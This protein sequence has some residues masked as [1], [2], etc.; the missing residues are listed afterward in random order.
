MLLD[1]V[2]KRTQ[3]TYREESSGKIVRVT[4]EPLRL[5]EL[6]A[7]KEDIQKGSLHIDEMASR[8][9]ERLGLLNATT[10]RRTRRRSRGNTSDWFY[11]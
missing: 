2:G 7:N 4:R 1:P 10:C 3:I 6:C 8:D 9:S 11:L 5:S